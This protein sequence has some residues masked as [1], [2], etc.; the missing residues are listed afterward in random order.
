[1]EIGK[2]Q[3][4]LYT[5]PGFLL[6]PLVQ[7]VVFA[8]HQNHSDKLLI[9]FPQCGVTDDAQQKQKQEQIVGFS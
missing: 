1:M 7:L 6:I 9:Q 5:E 3:F 4:P 2:L 8:T